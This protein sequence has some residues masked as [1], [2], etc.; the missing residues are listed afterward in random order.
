MNWAGE[1]F[2]NYMDYTPDQFTTMFTKGQVEVINE[3]LEGDGTV[4]GFRQ[5]MWSEVNIDETG[6]SDGFLPPT[7]TKQL[8]IFE[9]NDAY[10]VCIG[11]KLGL[12]QIQG[13][14]VIVFLLSSGTLVMER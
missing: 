13:Y 4:P 1:M 6:T 7:C 12:G 3:T 14:L 8:N 10:Q 5:Y 2:M 9:N 11:E